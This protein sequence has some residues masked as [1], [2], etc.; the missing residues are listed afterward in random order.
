MKSPSTTENKK[1]NE[2]NRHELPAAP[3]K[4][5]GARYLTRRAD[6]V[7]FRSLI[8]NHRCGG[9]GG[10]RGE[11]SLRETSPRATLSSS[12]PRKVKTAFRIPRVNHRGISGWSVFARE[13]FALF[14]AVFA[15]PFPPGH[16]FYVFYGCPAVFSTKKLKTL[17]SVDQK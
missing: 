7:F 5:A 14:L 9:G 1:K 3:I 6:A 4:Y 16:N 12:W 2:A 13:N 11:G 17:G 15:S 10:G 8:I